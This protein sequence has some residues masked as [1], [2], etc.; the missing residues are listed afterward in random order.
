MC[1]PKHVWLAI[2]LSCIKSHQYL[3]RDVWQVVFEVKE[4]QLTILREW[5][6]HVPGLSVYKCDDRSSHEELTNVYN[7]SNSKNNDRSHL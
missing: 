1:P 7:T 4:L 3:I 6:V 5:F 2:I